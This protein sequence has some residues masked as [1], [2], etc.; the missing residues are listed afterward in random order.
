MKFTRDQVSEVSIRNVERGSIRI[1]DGLIT[2]NIVV[3]QE[4]LI[5]DWFPDD[6]EAMSEQDLERILSL[7]PEIVI[8]GTGWSPRRPPNEFVYALARRGIGLEVMDTSAACRT[9]N[10]LLAEGRR[11]VAVLLLSNCQSSSESL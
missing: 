2:D 5:S 8:L 7:D 10:I 4:A 6:L 1:G 3:T 11:I 9:F